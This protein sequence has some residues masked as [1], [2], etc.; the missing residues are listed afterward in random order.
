MVRIGRLDR[1]AQDLFDRVIGAGHRVEPLLVLVVD[2]EMTAKVRLGD[3]AGRVGKVAA[4]SLE[5]W[6]FTVVPGHRGD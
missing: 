2:R 6:R 3:T 1:L 5:D 4:M